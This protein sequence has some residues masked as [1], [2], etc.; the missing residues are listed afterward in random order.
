VCP[1]AGLNV[2]A[3]GQV[4]TPAGNRTSV[5]QS[6]AH[7]RLILQ[8]CFRN[9]RRAVFDIFFN[10]DRTTGGFYYTLGGGGLVYK[11]VRK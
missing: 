2:M 11:V 8:S 1:I 5:L 9:C 6:V 7:S 10:L 4:S 3:K